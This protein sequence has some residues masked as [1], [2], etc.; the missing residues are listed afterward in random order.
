MRSSS[1]K[2][3]IGVIRD[4]VDMWRKRQGL[5][6]QA[7]A[8]ELV[9]IYFQHRFDR[10]WPIDFRQSGDAY[11][12][13]KANSERIW[14][15]L[16]DQTK[17]STLLPVNFVQVVLLALP[18]DIRLM[19][20]AEMLAPVAIS[21]VLQVADTPAESHTEL[22]VASARESGEAVAAM[23]GLSESTPVGEL[24]RAQAEILQA[25]AAQQAALR[26][27]EARLG[28]GDGCA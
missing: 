17:D 22:L 9:S 7:A 21:P 12:A 15:W 16:D 25:I 10:V 27:V 24:K 28:V 3:V 6:H 23:A 19:C 26:H 14:R 2:T 11:M 4:H 13:T 5:S 18:A 8:S 1:H 20:V